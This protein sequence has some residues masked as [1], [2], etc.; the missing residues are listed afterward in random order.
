MGKKYFVPI[1][2][3]SLDDSVSREGV[4]FEV[5]TEE[6][7]QRAH[8][9]E[10]N[11]FIMLLIQVTLPFNFRTVTKSQACVPE[12]DPHNP[13]KQGFV[14]RLLERSS[15]PPVPRGRIDSVKSFWAEFC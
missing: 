9:V 1:I 6:L 4:I 5:T 14:G 11:K 3:C 15:S 8:S 13:V 10:R 12:R 2:F 7:K